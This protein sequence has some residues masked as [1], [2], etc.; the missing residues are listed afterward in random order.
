M[1]QH[2]LQ[3]EGAHGE[4]EGREE[5]SSSEAR[6]LPAKS[7]DGGREARPPVHGLTTH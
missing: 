6:Q 2:Q 3:T 4:H 5:M 1:E 7:W